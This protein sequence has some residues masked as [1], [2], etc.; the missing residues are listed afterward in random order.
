MLCQQCHTDSNHPAS[1][2]TPQNT[3][4]GPHPVE[5]LMGRGC[6]TCH[7]QIH[8]SNAPSGPRFHQ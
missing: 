6:L 7:A 3:K 2:L 5:E 1:L 8:G 4:L